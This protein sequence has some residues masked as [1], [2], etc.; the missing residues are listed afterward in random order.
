MPEKF[1][2]FT[3]TSGN[4]GK[5]LIAIGIPESRQV[6]LRD[7]SLA[8]IKLPHNYSSLELSVY[9]AGADPFERVLYRYIVTGATELTSESFEQSLSLPALK[10]GHYRLRVSYLK[11]DGVWSVPQ[12]ISRIRIMPPWYASVPML[13]VYVIMFLSIA[14]F[15]VDRL[16]KRRIRALEQELRA[17]DSVF[18]SKV[19]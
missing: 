13:A 17:R 16:S 11:S 14:V 5:E 19:E 12:D 8:S 15:T 3:D 9:L 7:P 18:T 6:E 10:P 4:D 1:S 2:R